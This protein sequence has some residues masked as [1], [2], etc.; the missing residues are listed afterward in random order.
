MLGPQRRRA[1]ADA[2]ASPTRRPARGWSTCSG[3]L[4]LTRSSERESRISPW[5]PPNWVFGRWRSTQRPSIRWGSSAAFLSSGCRTIPWRSTEREVLGRREV[6]G[7]AGRAVGGAG[8]HPAVELVDPDDARVLEAPLLARDARRRARAAARDRPTSRRCRSRE[9]ATVRCEMPRR[10]ST[11][12]S[13]TVSPSTRGRGR[14][15]DG[16]DRIRPVAR[17]SGSGCRGGG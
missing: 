8:D 2:A 17:P 10:S 13:R 14:V 1:D 4:Q 3:A 12:A 6:D 9:R 16:V 7:R 15:E 5:A 11:R